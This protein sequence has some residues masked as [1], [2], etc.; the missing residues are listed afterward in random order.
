[1]VW[2]GLLLIP[3]ATAPFIYHMVGALYFW[4]VLLV[5]AG[6][7]GLC[8]RFASRRDDASARLLFWG[9]IV[10]L[11]LLMLLWIF[12]FLPPMQMRS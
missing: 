7:L 12:D 11:P 3:V 9:T 1:V 6:L 5:S 4:G 2:Y 8:L 10:Y